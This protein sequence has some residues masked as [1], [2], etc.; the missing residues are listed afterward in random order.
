MVG[1]ANTGLHFVDWAL[2]VRERER[3]VVSGRWVYVFTTHRGGYGVLV[4]LVSSGGV[5]EE[6][7]E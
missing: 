3:M 7:K 4:R 2:C 6:G 5:Q 1:W